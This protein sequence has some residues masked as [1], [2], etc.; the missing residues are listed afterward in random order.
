MSTFS[1]SSFIYILHNNGVY[2]TPIYREQVSMDITP[3]Y[4]NMQNKFIHSSKHTQQLF[5]VYTVSNMQVPAVI[6]VYTYT[7]PNIHSRNWLTSM[8]TNTVPDIQNMCLLSS[9]T[10]IHILFKIYRASVHHLCKSK[11]SFLSN[12]DFITI[13]SPLLPPL[14]PPPPPSPLPS[15]PLFM[16]LAKECTEKHSINLSLSLPHPSPPLSIKTHIHIHTHTH[17][18]HTYTS[19]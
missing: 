11:W 16:L 14:P 12:K 1:V 10:Y 15:S 7:V 19:L 13:S 2:A 8:L 18:T 6:N 5:N 17:T 4:D 3:P 9:C